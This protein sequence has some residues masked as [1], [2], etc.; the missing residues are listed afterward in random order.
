MTTPADAAK[1]VRAEIAS[2]Q[3]SGD[4]PDWP[5]SVRCYRD[6]EGPCIV[7]RMQAPAEHPWI[8]GIGWGASSPVPAIEEHL[9]TTARSAAAA[10]GWDGQ[11][12]ARVDPP[13]FVAAPVPRGCEWQ[14][15]GLNADFG[16][17]LG[18]APNRKATA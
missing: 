10:A 9:N 18:H 2:R 8:S 5:V 13:P 15:L 1:L 7:V 3:V 14:H 16:F 6:P 12:S 11:P 17:I 4:L